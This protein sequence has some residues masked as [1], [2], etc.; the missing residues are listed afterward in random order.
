LIAEEE[1]IQAELEDEAYKT[2][3]KKTIYDIPEVDDDEELMNMI[4]NDPLSIAD[5]FKDDEQEED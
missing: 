5:I 4:E 1:R 3:Q 2:S